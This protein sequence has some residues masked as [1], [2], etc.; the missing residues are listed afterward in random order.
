MNSPLSKY[1]LGWHHARLCY[2]HSGL[3]A[4]RLADLAFAM[5]RV[6]WEALPVGIHYEDAL[7]RE[8]QR[9]WQEFTAH[10]RREDYY[11]AHVKCWEKK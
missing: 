11:D 2:E 1:Q 4:V 10:H 9:G 6:D 3:G 5:G 7:S 8:Y